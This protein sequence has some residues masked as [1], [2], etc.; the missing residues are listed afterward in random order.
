M[1]R[2]VGFAAILLSLAFTAGCPYTSKVPLG[3]PD[4][5]SFDPRLVGFWM[6]YGT[7]GDS[8]M[9]R[10]LPFNDAEY[11]VEM[12]EQDKEPSRYRAFVFDIGAQQ[13]LHFNE[14]SKDG[15]PPEYCFARYAFS[16]SGELSLRFV[17]EKIVPKPLAADPKALKAFLASHLG[18]PALDDEDVRLLLRRRP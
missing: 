2:W 14:L 4:R 18:D 8:T 1:K 15:A 9:I 3:F 11:Y 7:E 5:Q 16:A 10:V 12:D 13:F 17:G 6:G